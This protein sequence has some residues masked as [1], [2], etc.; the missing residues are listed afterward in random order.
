MMTSTLLSLMLLFVSPEPVKEEK[1]NIHDA[2]AQ[3]LVS[4][5][6]ISNGDYSGKSIVLSMTPKVKSK[7]LIVVPAGTHFISEESSEQ[8]IFVV[9]DQVL[10]LTSSEGQ[11]YTIEGFCSQYSNAAPEEG[12]G[13]KM[14]L[15]KNDNLSKLSKY[16]NGKGFSEDV[17]QNAI[18]SVS[19]K[20][21]VSNIFDYDDE[22]NPKVK[23]LRS[24]VCELTKLENVWYNTATSRTLT[25]ERQIETTP[26]VITGKLEYKVEKPGKMSLSV[27]KSNGELVREIF[28]DVAINNVGETSFNFKGKVQGWEKG[29]YV[30]KV[31]IDEKVIHSQTFE[32]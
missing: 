23:D 31:K 19:D 28:K 15:T 6:A 32:V 1:I 22:N 24:Y 26:T 29:G 20:K 3:N 7:Y 11:E 21:S 14:T 30:V 13:F 2:V 25:P 4:L 12:S 8:D 17:K 10:A 16:M 9:E 18:W 5:N 27:Y